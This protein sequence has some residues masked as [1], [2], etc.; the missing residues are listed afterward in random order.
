MKGYVL[1]F[2]L[3]FFQS[4]ASDKSKYENSTNE[5]STEKKS[6]IYV[7]ITLPEDV[8]SSLEYWSI[9]YDC[10]KINGERE[11]NTLNGIT[12][13]RVEFS[14][15]DV[16]K[17]RLN[18]IQFGKMGYSRK[19]F[20]DTWDNAKFSPTFSN[21]KQK[22][23]CLR[24]EKIVEKISAY[25]KNE[26]IYKFDHVEGEIPLRMSSENENKNC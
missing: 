16:C 23:V 10:K 17:F 19:T 12:V 5:V 20:K 9:Q 2:G 11:A 18:N 14:S 4:C 1:F 25:D 22:G 26:I 21:K 24:V 13:E 8:K 3:I 15:G 7:S 6:K